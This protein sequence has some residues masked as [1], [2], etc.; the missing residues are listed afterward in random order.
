M[1]PP[2][3][4]RLMRTAATRKTRHGDV[5]A[6]PEAITTLEALRAITIDAAWQL[7]CEERVGSI[8][9]GKLAD[10]SIVDRNPLEVEPERLDEIVACETWLGGRP[11][12]FGAA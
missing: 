10:F 1:Y 2:E 7:F 8:A 9:P 6:A 11:T 4:F 12:R 5:L 3:P